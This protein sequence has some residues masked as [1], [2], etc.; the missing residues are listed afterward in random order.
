MGMTPEKLIVK[1]QEK[2]KGFLSEEDQEVLTAYIN[3]R[4]KEATDGVQWLATFTD[5]M[6]N[7][8]AVGAIVVIASTILG[9]GCNMF[10]VDEAERVVTVEYRQQITEMTLAHDEEVN[11]LN[12]ELELSKAETDKL[13]DICIDRL[14]TGEITPALQDQ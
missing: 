14:L 2:I 4:I 11:K 7:F 13:K 10:R 6:A 8:I 1:Y 12:V 5:R 9:I 3:Y